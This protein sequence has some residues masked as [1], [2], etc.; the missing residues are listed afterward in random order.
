MMLGSLPLLIRQRPSSSQLGMRWEHIRSL[1]IQ[2][3]AAAGVVVEAV[4]AAAAD[5]DDCHA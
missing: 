2:N 4:D 1:L 3:P 5:D